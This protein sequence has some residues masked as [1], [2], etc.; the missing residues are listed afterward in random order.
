MKLIRT[1][2]ILLIGVVAGACW[3]LAGQAPPAFKKEVPANRSLDANLFMQASAEYRACCLQAFNLAEERLKEATQKLRGEGTKPLAVVLDL[4]ETVLDNAGFQA[5]MIRS[6]LAYD[7]RLWDLWEKDYGANVGLIPGAKAFLDSA[8]NMGVSLVYI[9]NRN[10]RYKAETMATLKRLGIEVPE[11]Q[12]LLATTTSDKTARRAKA[13]EQFEIALLIGD[14]LRDFDD[15]YRFDTISARNQRV[16]AAKSEFGTRWI[17]LPNPAYGD[18]TKAF[19]F[20]EADQ[21][22]LVP[23]PAKP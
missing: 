16:D 13:A 22:L 4:D 7:Q 12:L 19:Q 6:G 1:M 17:I 5:M 9:S 15:R 20:S 8:K 11:A 2:T 3:S 14:N 18:W 21:N 10:D 23:T